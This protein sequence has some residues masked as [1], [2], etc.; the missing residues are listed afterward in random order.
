MQFTDTI[1]NSYVN[2]L[3]TISLILFYWYLLDAKWDQRLFICLNFSIVSVWIFLSGDIFILLKIF[4][5]IYIVF[6]MIAYKLTKKYRHIERFDFKLKF[7]SA[8]FVILFSSISIYAAIKNGFSSL[9]D[10]AIILPL[11]RENMSIRYINYL[12]MANNL[13]LIHMICQ[14]KQNNKWLRVEK[15]AFML[16]IL[17]GILS[18]SKASFAPPVVALFFI[19]SDKIAFYWKAFVPFILLI[20]ISF[21]IQKLFPELSSTEISIKIIERVI[22]NI[23]VLDYIMSIDE[24]QIYIYPNASPFYLMWPLFQFT[25]NTFTSSG[26][27]LHGTLYGDFSGFGPNPTFIMDH[28]LSSYGFGLPISLLLG[29]LLKFGNSSNYRVF[30]ALIAYTSLQDWYYSLLTISIFIFLFI[31]S[32]IV[33]LIYTKT[34]KNKYIRYFS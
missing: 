23:D 21:S 33:G 28:I 6:F 19:Y 4:T 3:F 11:L 9:D 12:T 29:F 2:I 24:S 20:L 22:K 14:A 8:I 27:W 25:Q 13:L 7:N 5:G 10:R 16:T 32:K 34:F 1:S 31:G 17:S 18:L 15:I 26:V 30:F